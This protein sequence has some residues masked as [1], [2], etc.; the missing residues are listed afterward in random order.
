MLGLKSFASPEAADVG[1]LSEEVE[2]L[3]HQS[4][5]LAAEAVDQAMRT[6]ADQVAKA[7]ADQLRQSQDKAK[8][9][10][11]QAQ[12]EL[13]KAQRYGKA[14][15]LEM[16]SAAAPGTVLTLRVK[17]SDADAFA[18]GKLDFN[19]FQQKAEIHAYPGSGYGLTSLNSWAK[20]HNAR[21]V[22]R[23]QRF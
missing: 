2:K 6:S 10:L 1:Q 18:S 23:L 15:Q 5:Q 9:Q 20:E 13:G 14:L 17:K 11:E 16:T 3:V 8:R 21:S 19:A 22:I 7:R 12:R 4:Q